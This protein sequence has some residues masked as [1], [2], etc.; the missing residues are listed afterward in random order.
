MVSRFGASGNAGCAVVPGGAN[1][2]G[3][4]HR[5]PRRRRPSV[6]R[7]SGVGPKIRER[8][9]PSR[10]RNSAGAAACGLAGPSRN[11][12]PTR[13]P[14]PRVFDFS[15]GA[16][17]GLGTP[18]FMAPE[19]VGDARAV[20]V[21][22]DVYGLGATLYCLLTG[23]VPYPDRSDLEKLLAHQ[24]GDPFPALEQLRPD[25]PRELQAIAYKM[26][27]KGPAKRYPHPGAAADDLAR[28]ACGANSP[29]LVAL[30]DAASPGEVPRPPVGSTWGLPGAT[31]PAPGTM[32]MA[33]AASTQ[34]Q[35]LAS[36]TI[37]A[38]P[39]PIASPSG[40]AKP[41]GS[42]AGGGGSRAVAGGG[43]WRRLAHARRQQQDGRQGEGRQERQGEGHR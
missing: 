31:P 38:P 6:A 28:F 36:T 2:P 11:R 40:P 32:P 1:D 24:R 41:S 4:S 14:R 39:P 37:L 20:D 9:S 19:Q 13:S 3:G 10:K 7:S 43:V 34:Q 26:M 18:D 33:P 5:R 21:R 27:A 42:L 16:P 8:G 25:V 15:R 12:C 17:I 22:A 30:L 29:R 23:R 35:L